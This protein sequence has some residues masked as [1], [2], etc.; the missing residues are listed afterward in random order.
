MAILVQDVQP[1]AAP[2]AAELH[3]RF[4][5]CGGDGR[6]KVELF[7]SVLGEAVETGQ[8]DMSGVLLEEA[9]ELCLGRNWKRR[10]IEG[11]ATYLVEAEAPG[12]QAISSD[13]FAAVT[14]QRVY[15]EIKKASE[16]PEFYFTR[17]IPV[18]PSGI[19][20]TEIVPEIAGM[21]D[22]SEE[23]L[24]AQGYPFAGFGPH[25]ETLPAGKKFGLGVQITEETLSFSSG[26]G[27]TSSIVGQAG[28]IGTFL[29]YRGEIQRIDVVTGFVNPYTRDG[30]NTNTYLTTGAYVN[31]Q[32]G[33]PLV[34]Y[35]DIS[36]CEQLLAEVLDPDTG[37]PIL[38]SMNGRK[39]I[40]M[41]SED[42]RARALVGANE[43]R[44]G[45]ITTGTGLQ[46]VSGNPLSGLAI[47]VV[48]SQILYQRVLATLESEVAKARAGYFYGSMDAFGWKE[49]WPL[50]VRQQGANSDAAFTHD[51]VMRWKARYLGAPFV[52]N[53]RLV[54]RNE[55]MA[56]A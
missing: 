12:G 38:R 33:A 37:L 44:T 6:S 26:T 9:A 39:L 51:V 20:G 40:V 14:G 24:E 29:G 36:A 52:R 16:L 1:S 5:R 42:M 25:T 41:P 22:V 31:K 48:S 28:R 13:F 19:L 56:W 7:E 50:T 27:L 23:M 18:M 45:D 8:M 55:D 47:E 10:L 2:T 11:R 17:T 32:T 3:S 21:G 43:I 30:T 15:S 46:T 54:T 53:P 4:Q 35:S 49:L 34:D